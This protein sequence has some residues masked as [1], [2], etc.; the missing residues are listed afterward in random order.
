MATALKEV[1]R[2]DPAWE[3]RVDLAAA[4]RL[5]ARNNWDDGIFNHFTLMVPGAKDR[6]FVK[7]H[8]LMMSEVTAGNLIAVDFEGNT[9]EGEG[10]IETSARTIHTA[11]HRDV[12]HAGCIL[13]AHPPHATWLTMCEDNRIKMVNQ[14]SMYFYDR[15]AYDDLFIGAAMDDEK[16]AQFGCG[17]GDKRVLMSANHGITTMAPTVAEAYFEFRNI[18]KVCREMYM[19]AC[20]GKEPRII[21]DNIARM[22]AEQL[23]AEYVS[24]AGL[25]FKAMKRELDADEPDYAT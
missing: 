13:H 9:V 22:T 20:A 8:G 15:V 7:A 21:S 10:Y 17:V 23:R 2:S 19:V 24:A 12:P 5:A 4:H 16:G 14:N 18:E 1:P 25:S 11:I 6:F 3:A